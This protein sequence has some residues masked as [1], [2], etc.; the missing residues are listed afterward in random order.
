MAHAWHEHLHGTHAQVA[1][2]AHL[3]GGLRGGEAAEDVLWLRH[4]HR[5]PASSGLRSDVSPHL[6]PARLL[7]MDEWLR[8]RE[9]GISH[10][11]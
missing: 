10:L 11:R 7:Q 1:C 8:V 4:L 9:Q 3:P 5:R 6:V 2:L